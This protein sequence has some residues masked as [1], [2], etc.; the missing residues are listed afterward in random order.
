M[1]VAWLHS[2]MNTGNEE[3]FRVR[4]RCRYIFLLRRRYVSVDE[5]RVAPAVLF[6]GDGSVPPSY[7]NYRNG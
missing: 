3:A 2:D 5:S 7:R 6:R 1:L 4:P